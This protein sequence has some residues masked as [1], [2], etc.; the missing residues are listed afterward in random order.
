[1]Q[2]DRKL[3]LLQHLGARGQWALDLLLQGGVAEGT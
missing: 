2:P 1:M 3:Q